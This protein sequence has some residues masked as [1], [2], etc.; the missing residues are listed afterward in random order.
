MSRTTET[1]R[2]SGVGQTSALHREV[3]LHVETAFHLEA[4]FHLETV[5][6]AKAL[7][8]TET[9]LP[10]S[11]HFERELVS[12]NQLLSISF[13]QPVYLNQC[14]SISASQ[15]VYP[16]GRE[17]SQKEQSLRRGGVLGRE[18]SQEAGPS[19]R[20]LYDETLRAHPA[21]VQARRRRRRPAR[22]P[23]RLLAMRPYSCLRNPYLEEHSYLKLTSTRSLH[24]FDRL[25]RPTFFGQ[26]SG[27]M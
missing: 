17:V 10:A 20:S 12:L 27:S 14:L 2:S 6:H 22:N 9:V 25:S 26:P 23:T 21:Q 13:S 4:A 5:L 7:L 11:W 15:E 16:Q 18:V 3:A 24:S 1:C 19:K 8:C